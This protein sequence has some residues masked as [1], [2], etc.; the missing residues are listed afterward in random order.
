MTLKRVLAVQSLSFSGSTLTCALL[1]L[2]P[3][4][5]GVGEI[6]WVIDEHSAYNRNNLP[7]LCNLC[8]RG[9]CTM[10]DGIE[11]K[12][13]T[14]PN[15][16]ERAAVTLNTEILAV[17]DKAPGIYNRFVHPNR[18]WEA[19]GIVLFKHPAAMAL[20]NHRHQNVWG[21][22]MDPAAY[23]Y[24]Y[25]RHLDFSKERFDDFCVV[26]YEKLCADPT[27]MVAKIAE[28]FGLAAPEQL[29]TFPPYG[30]HNVLGNRRTFFDPRY[31][32]QAIRVDD[33]WR[34]ELAKDELDD[35]VKNRQCM[36]MWR[37]LKGMAL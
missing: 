4:V 11:R 27:A 16:Y 2:I 30:A 31:A 10:L 14:T 24:D 28:R 23:A 8:G 20:S 37:Q 18:K 13:L 7:V 33:R 19:L 32:Q 6:H 1:N 34:T 22:K 25:Q 21:D 12:G 26:Q 3:G 17:S 35:I 15:L 5:R 9:R 36:A 29:S